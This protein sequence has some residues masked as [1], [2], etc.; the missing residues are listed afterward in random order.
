MI[1]E[2][3][4]EINQLLESKINIYE[5][6]ELDPMETCER[7]IKSQYRKKALIYHPD[8]KTGDKKKFN[9]LFQAYKVLLSLNLRQKYD[10]IISFRKKKNLNQK[11]Y[12]ILINDF[13]DD[14]KKSE[15]VIQKKQNV[16]AVDLLNQV[17]I[18]K[19]KI[20]GLRKREE[21]EKEYYEKIN[22]K[23]NTYLNSYEKTFAYKSCFDLNLK[24]NFFYLCKLPFKNEI[25]LYW[26]SHPNNVNFM[27]NSYLKKT[28]EVF[29]TIN[30]VEIKKTDEGNS[31]C[32]YAIIKYKE[33]E[34]AFKAYDF[35]NGYQM[36]LKDSKLNCEFFDLVVD[37]RIFNSDKIYIEELNK[38]KKIIENNANGVKTHEFTG[39]NSEKIDSILMKFVLNAMK[40]M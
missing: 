4:D 12:N 19:L 23:T 28:M 35:V 3:D 32:E 2:A 16:F 25:I 8:K 15:S 7:V 39:S 34:N 18:E 20:Q 37:C 14:L 1:D 5:L 10:K 11:K 40:K 26:K 36:G 6:I 30:S 22:K 9:L 29:G 24:E 17:E 38:K 31:N 13:R 21:C 27:C 33:S